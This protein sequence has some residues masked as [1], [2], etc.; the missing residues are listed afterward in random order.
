MNC[1]VCASAIGLKGK[2]EIVEHLKSHKKNP[3]FMIDKFADYMIAHN[4]QT[5]P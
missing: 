4:P 2:E 3:D 5:P 1:P